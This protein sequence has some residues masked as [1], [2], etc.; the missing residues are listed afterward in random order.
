MNRRNVLI[1]ISILAFIMIVGGISYSYFV[2]NKEVGEVSLT[3]G[4]ISIDL[5]GI[6]GNQTLTNVVPVSDYDGINSNSYFD[7]TVN[8]TVDTERIYY[9]V[10]L[11]PNSGN[12]LDTSYLKTYL[13]DQSNNEIKGITIYN[14]LG[15]SEVENGKVI[16]KGIV[17]VN[18][19]GT[20]KNE[21][22]NFRLR[23]WLDENYNEQTSKTFAFDIYL[24][25]KNVDA[26]FELPLGVNLLRK[27]IENKQS[28]GTC[29]NITWTD[30][31]DNITYLSG[32]N[33][34]IDMN[35]VWYSG[36]LW[37]VV[38]IYPDGTMK[39]VTDK[40]ITM[41]SYNTNSNSTFY[42]NSNN[43]SFA[44]NWLNEEFYDT[45]YNPNFF[46]DSSKRWNASSTDSLPTKP[47]TTTLVD[48]PVGLLNSFELYNSYR[49]SDS[50]G[51]ESTTYLNSYLKNDYFSWLL[52][53]HDSTTVWTIFDGG[54]GTYNPNSRFGVRPSIYLNSNLEFTGNGT[55]NDPFKIVGDKKTGKSNDKVNTR[56]SGEY[57]KLKSGNNELLFRIV[58]V[59]DD[60]TKIVAQNYV[61]DGENRYYASDSSGTIWGE[62]TTV[63][64]DTW[65]TYLNN[66]YYTSLTSTYG[67]LFDTATYYLGISGYNYKLGVCANTT[68]G[69]TKVCDKTT[70]KKDLKIGLLRYGE[71]FAIQ[72]DTPNRVGIWLINRYSGTDVWGLNRSSNALYSAPNG[73]GTIIVTLHLKE[74]VK[75]LSGSGTEY[76]PYV[77][78]L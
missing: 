3:T 38:S 66:T 50:T 57:I 72:L 75:I 42:A 35:Y 65:Y 49:C 19:N 20:T 59:I 36:K 58:D 68:S 34:C 56:L 15:D 69:N 60:K 61:N 43:K 31:E 74:S 7:F 21:T 63:G 45:L 44:Y 47:G 67:N 78:G 1:I 77:V 8:S 17:E 24:Y 71:L 25:A 32:T 16:Y 13:T 27:N 2:Y 11:L 30:Q 14:D 37:R 23:L 46:I 55:I 40:P 70:Y 54:Y 33:S 5:S 18:N 26:N 10:Y 39:L 9:E 29:T 51:C 64:T 22:K 73:E 76:D 62:G 28:N 41:I 6:N 52:N 53:S 48:S 4:D 12:T